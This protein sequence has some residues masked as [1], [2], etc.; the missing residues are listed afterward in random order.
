MNTE[1]RTGNKNKAGEQSC[2][3]PCC[4]C[5]GMAEM[6]AKCCEDMS[7]A[8]DCCSMMREMMQRTCGGSARGSKK[9]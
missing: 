8:S 4:R 9:Q 3:L 2:D 7:E 1:D 6:T 5:Q